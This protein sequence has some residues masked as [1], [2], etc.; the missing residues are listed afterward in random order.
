MLSQM[1]GFP[2][3][4]SLNNIASYISTYLYL[5]IYPTASLSSH[6][7]MDTGFHTLDTMN[8]AAVNVG[9]QLLLQNN[10]FIS[11]FFF[12]RLHPQHMEVPRLGVKSEL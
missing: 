12:L 1:A 6:L 2:S 8:N 4:L 7:L 3:F 5:S 11:F 9:V 10:D